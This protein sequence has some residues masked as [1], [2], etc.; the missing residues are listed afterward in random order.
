MRQIRKNDAQVKNRQFLPPPGHSKIV[1]IHINQEHIFPLEALTKP[2]KETFGRP[3][4]SVR[5]RPQPSFVKAYYRDLEFYLSL[6][7]WSRRRTTAEKDQ[8]MKIQPRCVLLALSVCTGFICA[9]EPAMPLPA[10]EEDTLVHTWLAKPVEESRPLCDMEDISAWKHRGAGNIQISQEHAKTGT[11]SLKMICKTFTDHPS[12]NGRPPGACTALFKIDREDWG[13]YN[14]LSFWVYPDL[15][16]FRTISMS[17]VLRNEGTFPVP[18]E[19]SRRGRNYFLLKNQQWNHVVWEIAHLSRDK[20]AGVEFVYRMQGNDSGA[21][22]TVQYFID[23]LEL[24]HVAP[25]H[26]EGWNVAPGRIAYS[27]TGYPS[28]GPKIAITSDEVPA[29]FAVINVQSGEVQEYRVRKT[30]TQLGQFTVLDFSDVTE[31]GIYTVRAGHL[32]TEPFRISRDVWTETIWKTINCFYCLRC[33]MEIPGIHGDCHKDWLAKHNGK[34]LSY[35]GGWHDAG[36]LS[37]GLRNTCEAAYAMFLLAEQLPHRDAALAARLLDEARWGLDWILKNRFGDGYRATWGTMDFW[38]D[39]VIGTTDDMLAERVGNDAYHNFHAVTAEAIAFRLLRQDAPDLAARSLKCAREDWQFAIEQLRRPNLQTYSIGVAASVEL[40][41]A[42]KQA[43]YAEKAVE[44]AETILA[45]QQRDE[46]DWDIPL[47]GF[48]YESPAKRRIQHDSH[49]GEIQSPIVALVMLC[50]ALPNHP[51]R[52]RWEAAVELYASYLKRVAE[53]TAPYYMFPASVY[54]LEESK[55]ARFRE[56]VQNGIRLSD[57]HYL[58]RFPV[59]TMLRGNYGVLLSQARALS[60]AARLLNDRTLA[61]LASRQ[62]QWVVGLN[63]FCQSTMYGEGHDFAPQYTA[64]SGNIVG[65]LPVGVQTSRNQDEPFWPAD[66]CYN[67][68]EIWVH[69]SSRWLA[70]LADLES[71]KNGE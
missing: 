40:F 3:R 55:D 25:D 14:R 26:C 69:P 35:N 21:T 46:P 22:D 60:A 56:Q 62:L 50:Q 23:T 31:P 61:D 49:V 24:Q 18:D 16:G 47:R 42:T 52:P 13:N 70:I 53:F 19:Y 57:T 11:K 4:G 38:T 10:V 28:H 29:E 71:L 1:K 36:D 43:D 32:K 45:C 59:W 68:K 63:P 67:F 58:R 48:F 6:R 44:L 9:D 7:K 5:D 20:V 66:N 2:G 8:A 64:T 27:H 65:G 17:V 37:Q 41:L 51:K 39:N 33:G 15:P 30:Q 54:S 34:T 12:E